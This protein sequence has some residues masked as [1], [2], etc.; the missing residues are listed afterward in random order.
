MRRLALM[1]MVVAL[2]MGVMVAPAGAGG[3]GSEVGSWLAVDVEGSFW[4]INVSASGHINSIDS[5]TFPCEGYRTHLWGALEAVDENLFTVASLDLRCLAGPF[6]GTTF[7]GFGGNDLIYDPVMDTL[8]WP[9]PDPFRDVVA[10][11]R[12]CD[13][14]DFVP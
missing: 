10:C 14:Y 3:S 13:P 5:G 6:K 12:P 7:T 1:L 11:R 2:T 8:L 9:N 4:Q